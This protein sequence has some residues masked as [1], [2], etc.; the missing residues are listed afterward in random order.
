MVYLLLV[1]LIYGYL[2]L[3][4]C[5]LCINPLT[6]EI[7]IYNAVRVNI[8]TPEIIQVYGRVRVVIFTPIVSVRCA[9]RIQPCYTGNYI[10]Q[11]KYGQVW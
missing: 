11:V 4:T 3:Y 5:A 2:F 1:I 8:I 9:P 6:I 7:S 10:Q